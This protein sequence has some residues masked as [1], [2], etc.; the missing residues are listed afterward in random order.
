M[1]PICEDT[2]RIC[3]KP[4]NPIYRNPVSQILRI[5]HFSVDV[6]IKGTLF[7]AQNKGKCSQADPD[8]NNIYN[9]VHKV[10]IYHESYATD[11]H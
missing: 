9:A 4:Q 6:G 2:L 5:G 8:Q 1:N 7:S 10:G 3:L 11:K